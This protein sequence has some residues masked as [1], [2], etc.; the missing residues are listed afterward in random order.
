MQNAIRGLILV[1]LGLWLTTWGSWIAIILSFLGIVLMVGTP[2]LLLSTRWILGIAAAV[3]ILSQPV[4]ALVLSLVP[5][6]PLGGRPCC[7]RS[8][9]SSRTPTTG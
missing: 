6:T 7:C 9:G 5:A 3:V 4:N 2:L 8:S 1:A